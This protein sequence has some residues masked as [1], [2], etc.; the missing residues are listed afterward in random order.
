MRSRMALLGIIAILMAGN[1]GMQGMHKRMHVMHKEGVRRVQ[2]VWY[3]PQASPVPASPVP[4]SPVQVSPV[5]PIT[6]ANSTNTPDWACIREHESG[7]DYQMPGGGAYQFE[8]GTWQAVTGL[9]GS[10]E[11]YPPAVQDAAALK[12]HAE[13]GFEP[14]TTAS[15]CGLG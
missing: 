9:S 13:R 3:Q 15:L 2:W 14:W 7:D 1:T 12:L 5:V 4:A 6:D 11:D 8:A 10:A